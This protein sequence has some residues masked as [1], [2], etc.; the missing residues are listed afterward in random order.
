MLL[1]NRVIIFTIGKALCVLEHK[2]HGEKGRIEAG[3][4]GWN[5]TREGLAGYS[6][7]LGLYPPDNLKSMR[8][9]GKAKS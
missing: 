2:V 1:N 5:Q 8:I 4:V 6:N 9:L 7:T 3:E